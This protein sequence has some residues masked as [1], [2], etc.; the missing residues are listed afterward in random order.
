MGADVLIDSINIKNRDNDNGFNMN[1]ENVSIYFARQVKSLYKGLPVTLYGSI[2]LAVLVAVIS[3]RIQ[4][5]EL[6]LYWLGFYSVLIFLRGLSYQAYL[7]SRLNPLDT[8]FWMLILVVGCFISGAHW[9]SYAIM[10]ANEASLNADK[11]LLFHTIMVPVLIALN[12]WAMMMYSTNVV[13]F[14]SFSISSV[15]PYSLYLSL[16][17]NHSLITLGLVLMFCY[18]LLFVVCLRQSSRINDK[19]KYDLLKEI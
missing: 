18:C 15:F 8:G 14:L 4:P 2:V 19:L 9:S 5:V 11:I 1:P 12:F 3:W 17:Q 6:T 10:F 16:S 7:S 13:V